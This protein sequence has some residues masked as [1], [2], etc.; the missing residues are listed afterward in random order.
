M[1]RLIKPVLAI[2]EHGIT[3]AM[4]GRT[5]LS[6]GGP[7]SVDSGR[8]LGN[9]NN[10]EHPGLIGVTMMHLLM[11]IPFSL[12]A[13]IELT[14]TALLGCGALPLPESTRALRHC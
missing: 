4:S 1:V 13:S 5:V 8:T 3:R 14:T 12:V 2:A 6:R 7:G 11:Y 10:K 9:M